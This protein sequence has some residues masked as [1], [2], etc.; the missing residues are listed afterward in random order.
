MREI[1]SLTGLRFLAA[2]YVFIFHINLPMRT[3]LHWLAESLQAIIQQGNLGVA[4]FFVLSGFVLTYSHLKDFPN[5]QFKGLAYVAR[6]MF[7]RLARIYPVFFAGLLA[8]TLISI[9]LNSLP[10]WWLMLMSATFLQTYFPSI[11]MH[12]YDSGAWSVANEIFFYLLFPLLLPL[13][14][15]LRTHLSLLTTLAATILLCFSIGILFWQHPSW[16]PQLQYSFPP[17]RLWEF[18]AGILIGILVFRFDWEM[19]AWSA[20]LL[21]VVTAMY[22]ALV[23]PSFPPGNLIHDIVLLPTLA[24]LLSALY[25]PRQSLAF[26][27]LE[28]KPMQYLGKISYCFYIAQLP[29]LFVLDAACATGRVAHNNWMVFP[30]MLLVNLLGAAFLHKVIEKPAHKAL[31]AFYKRR[32]PEITVSSKLVNA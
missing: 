8:C 7:K 26:S 19:P 9:R 6:F 25:Q 13:C 20:V 30:I 32:F 28:S 1:K 14:L 15:R 3:P 21:V 27:W 5:A 17:A 2:F 22:L 12:W 11:S 18:V 23:A 4:V 31:M 24:V 10:E 16:H 29:L